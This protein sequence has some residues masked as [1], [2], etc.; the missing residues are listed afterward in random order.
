MRQKE[1]EELKDEI[2]HTICKKG[3][4]INV[5]ASGNM[6]AADWVKGVLEMHIKIDDAQGTILDGETER[7]PTCKRT[8][9]TSGAYCKWCGTYL[10]EVGWL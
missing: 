6:D 8:V 2:W 10:R 1:A 9:G 4:P 5:R 7:C 3:I